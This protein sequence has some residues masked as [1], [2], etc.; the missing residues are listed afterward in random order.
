MDW[1]GRDTLSTSQGSQIKS[2]MMTDS[3]IWW[4]FFSKPK[5]FWSM[6]SN[7]KCIKHRGMVSSRNIWQIKDQQ[8]KIRIITET[9]ELL[10]HLFLIQL[11][12]Q[13]LA[14]YACQKYH[15]EVWKYTFNV[16]V[17]S[18]EWTYEKFEFGQWAI[19]TFLSFNTL[20]SSS[21]K[22]IQWAK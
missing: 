21:S 12:Y 10:A 9:C 3:F 8:G 6:Y 17:T 16:R 2:L 18:R 15:Y 19:P 22:W 20:K 14:F 4:R 5:S 11:S 7:T 1:M 13:L